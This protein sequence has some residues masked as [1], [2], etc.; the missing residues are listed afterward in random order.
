MKIVHAVSNELGRSI[1]GVPGDQTGKEIRDADW[2][3]RPWEVY[4]ECTDAYLADK[5]ATIAERIAS[6][7]FGYSQSVRWS[8]L[9]AIRKAGGAD[10]LTEAEAGDFD[11]SSLVLSCY[12]LAGLDIKASGYTQ[13]L[14]KILLKTGKFTS[15]RD[16]EHVA[17]DKLAARGGIY[18]APGKH[19][20]MCVPAASAA[21][22]A[23]SLGKPGAGGSGASPEA[24]PP[25]VEVLG[26]TVNVRDEPVTG[27]IC[28][29]ARR[30]ERFPFVGTETVD[31]DG[32]S[33]I[34]YEIEWKGK[35]AFITGKGKYTRLVKE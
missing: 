17:S 29:V 6:G 5:A 20:V 8:G 24:L 30:G 28:G 7:N 25:Y 33:G 1:G 18:L 21:A 32:E 11:C 26:S 14:E 34:W 10:H 23:G 22:G 13:N 9:K 35:Q 19:V 16:P 2:Y 4:I 3:D 27:K 15:Y 31:A 12:I